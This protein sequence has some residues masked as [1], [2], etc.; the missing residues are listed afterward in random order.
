[1]KTA[2]I[3][4]S[5]SGYGRATAIELL[6]RGWN[7]VATM[8]SPQKSDL[9]TSERLRV[10]PL[11][12]T[13]RA[14]IA[15]AIED[16]I[17]AFGG[18][19]VVVNNAGIGLLSALEAT[20]EQTIRDV[21]ETN[22]FGVIAVSQAVVPHF[23]ARRAG[24]L[25]NVTSSAAIVP[26]PLVSV[27]NASKCA[28]EGF[29]ESLSY[30]LAFFGVTAKI[31]EPGYGPA[32]SFI[33]NAADRMKGLVPEAYAP[34]AEQLARGRDDTKTTTDADVARAVC[35]AATDGSRRLRYP[36]GPD[37]EELAALRRAYPGDDYVE[38]VR[39]LMGPAR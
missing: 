2:L 35:L 39:A 25:I 11:D 15:R 38:H 33:A 22:T 3:T 23:R 20:P 4:G 37:A 18:L 9:P 28:I 26:F 6:E 19:D 31:V 14:S 34:Y 1:M 10:L 7:V 29:T 5:S 21:F 17:A 27:Y 8:R 16:G 13:D 24:T 32:T 12:V 30:E 36:A